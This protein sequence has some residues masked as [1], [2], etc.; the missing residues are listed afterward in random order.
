MIH[1]SS[2]QRVTL[3]RHRIPQISTPGVS[4]I[5]ATLAHA[6]DMSLKWCELCIFH[7]ELQR[8]PWMC[9]L[10]LLKDCWRRLGTVM[11]PQQAPSHR[12]SEGFLI[13]VWSHLSQED[14]ISCWVPGE[15]PYLSLPGQLRPLELAFLLCF[16][17]ESCSLP[18]SPLSF[19]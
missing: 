3:V 12:C 15:S 16:S 7:L 19:N 13:P 2:K 14:L 11:D 10:G 18:S 17:A 6:L 8:N 1:G 4:P 5:P 9:L